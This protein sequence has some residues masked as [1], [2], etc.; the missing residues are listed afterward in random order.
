[1]P[2]RR[3]GYTFGGL[4]RHFVSAGAGVL[5]VDSPRA[6]YR[7]LECLTDAG[8]AKFL[9]EYFGER[10]LLS[11][12]K[13]TL[14][15][16]PPDAVAGWHQDARSFSEPVRAL[17]I[18]AAFSPCGVDA[19]SL[20]IFA[21]RF[22]ALVERGVADILD[23][24]TAANSGVGTVNRPA[25]ALGDADI[26]DDALINDTAAN[27]GIETVERPV[28]EL[29]DA[30]LFDEMA[31]HRTGVNKSMTQTRYAIEMWF[32]A[33]SMFPRQQVPLVMSN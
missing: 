21:K 24:D 25:F 16:T 23:D 7:Y 22:D 27:G 10:P 30:V 9:Q 19:P 32:F 13:T 31:M 6:L 11:A 15:R 26:L 2:K 8:I 5:A 14:R 18:W 3:M 29:G 4:D 20:D 17:N 12:K 28:F 33:A 1:M